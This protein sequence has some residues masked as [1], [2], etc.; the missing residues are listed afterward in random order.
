LGD[1]LLLAPALAAVRERQPSP[2]VNLA[3]HHGAARLLAASGLIDVAL[4]RDDPRLAP[5]FGASGGAEACRDVL[6]HVDAA[7]A[8][9]GDPEGIVAANLRKLGAR[10]TSVAPSQPQA[11]SG[12]HLAEHLAD[13][14]R[15]LGLVGDRLPGPPLLVSPPAEAAWAG[16]SLGAA[17]DRARPI[18]AVHPGSGGRRKNWPAAGF[19]AVIDALAGAATVV[20]AGGPADEEA[21]AAVLRQAR[22]RPI[23][24][25]D[26]PLPRVAALLA[27]CDA[28]VGNDSG[29]THLA[30]LLGVST[31]AL[32]GP[33]DPAVWRPW[34]PRT[35]VLSWATGPESL[36]PA[37]V[38]EVVRG[39]LTK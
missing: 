37:K 22:S 12:R 34:G 20:L 23:S 1:T 3:A 16:G 8:W 26:L 39:A 9:L 10:Q 35:Q 6:G 27:R 5:L 18:V 30:A 28:F 15:S 11:A 14:L 7:V 29:L 32:F 33:T 24:A 4:S 36:S 25:T 19:A 38:V 2:R 31:V 13:A 17:V 21:V